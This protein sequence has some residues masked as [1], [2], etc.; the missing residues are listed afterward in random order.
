MNKRILSHAC[1]GV[2]MLAAW[3]G[4][5]APARADVSPCPARAFAV[6]MASATYGGDT[7]FEALDLYTPTGA[8][9]EPLMVFV[10]GGGWTRGDKSQYRALGQTFAA[11][12]I[13]FIALNYP[14]APQARV[15]AQATEIDRALKWALDNAPAKGYGPTKVYLMGHASGA[16]LATLAAIDPK[17]LSAGGITA[18]A[19]AGVISLDGLGFNPSG[20]AADATVNPARYRAY[21]AAFGAEPAR[22][23]QYDCNP[24]L[25]GTL[26]HFLVVHGIDDYLSPES[27]SKQLVDQLTGVGA[28]VIYL[29]PDARDQDGVLVNLVR[30]PDDPTFAAIVRF[31]GGT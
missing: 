2:A 25:K 19:I 16:E 10:H 6:Q 31:T 29:Q 13:A 5:S 28:K 1:F 21:M 27:Q 9:G 18:S 3:A 15:D 26:P 30:T 14:L 22:W 11:C 17:A 24:F 7:T 8:A 4:F 12:G 20:Q 23:Q